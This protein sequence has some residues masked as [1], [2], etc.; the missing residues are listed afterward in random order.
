MSNRITDK[1]ALTT[2]LVWVLLKYSDQSEFCFQT[3]LNQTIL[4]QKGIVLEE[5]CL[6][7]LDRQYYVGGRMVYR[8]FPFEGTTISLWDEETY[9]DELSKS[10]KEFL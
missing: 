6:V 1:N 8:Q 7:R 10:L 5:G 4:A 2:G 9:T 3:T